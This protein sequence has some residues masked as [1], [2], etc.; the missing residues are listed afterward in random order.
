MDTFVDANT[1][2]VCLKKKNAVYSLFW[3]QNGIYLHEKL[4]K[5]G[6][7]AG[8]ND[9]VP[10]SICSD[11]LIE[12]DITLKFLEKCEKSKEIFHAEL[13]SKNELSDQKTSCKDQ[14]CFKLENIVCYEK[15]ENNRKIDSET[16]TDSVTE[17]ERSCEDFALSLEEAKCGECGSHRRCH[18]W[19]PPTT[20]TCP[21]CQKVFGRKF[22]FKLHL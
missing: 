7:E 19:S 11:C 12:L 14:V 22:N 9:L 21:Y 20:H 5:V 16:N 18:H 17:I 4:K 15:I 13:S 6:L 10:S 2:I 3:K 1:C 8:V